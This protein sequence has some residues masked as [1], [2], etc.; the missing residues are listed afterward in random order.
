[1]DTAL[2]SRNAPVVK[3]ASG[4]ER[5]QGYKEANKDLVLRLE[6]DELKS[7]RL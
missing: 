1:M 3:A 7:K 2:L 4:E 5:L 6:I